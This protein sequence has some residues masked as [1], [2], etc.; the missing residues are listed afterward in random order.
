MFKP[1]S[2]AYTNKLEKYLHRSQGLIPIQKGDFLLFKNILSSFQATGIS[3]LDPDVILQRFKKRPRRGD[4]DPKNGNLCDTA[5]KDT[6]GVEARQ[7][8]SSLHSLQVQNKLLHHENE[9]LRST[10]KPLE[11][12]QRE[13]FHSSAVFWSPRKVREARARERVKEREKEVPRRTPKKKR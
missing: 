2:T 12:H 4:K 1:L 11:L 3:P 9:G 6:S 10:S 8:R 7:L 5:V 13:E